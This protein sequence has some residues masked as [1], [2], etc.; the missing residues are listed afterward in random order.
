[1]GGQAFGISPDICKKLINSNVA[2]EYGFAL[3][4]LTDARILMIQNVH[5][6]D[7]DELPFD[8]EHRAGPIQFRLAPDATQATIDAEHVRLRAVL[9][10]ALRPYIGAAASAGVAAMLAGGVMPSVAEA[11]TM[12]R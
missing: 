6:G 1:M 3:R 8:L 11:A 4:A 2:V 5:Y 9:V 12:T 7:R 10:D